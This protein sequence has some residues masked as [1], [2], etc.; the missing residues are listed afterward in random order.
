[1]LTT[2]GAL[3]VFDEAGKESAHVEML[4]AF[5][6]S[7]GHGGTRPTLAVAGEGIVISD[8]A[9]KRLVVVDAHHW[10]VSGEIPL[11]AAPIAVLAT[12]LSPEADE[13]DHDGED[14]GNDSHDHDD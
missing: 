4:A 14:H 10:K 3:H 2:D 11:T 5:E 6:L 13:H 8:P 1:M 12:G 7:E 9:G